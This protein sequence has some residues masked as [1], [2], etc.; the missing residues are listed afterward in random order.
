MQ[1]KTE[2]TYKKSSASLWTDDDDDQSH[3]RIIN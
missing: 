2:Y 3:N 1:T